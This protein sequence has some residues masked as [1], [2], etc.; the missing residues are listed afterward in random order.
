MC[1]QIYNYFNTNNLL[2]EQQYGFRS[3]HLT[4]LATIKL[5]DS[6][7]QNIDNTRLTKTPVILFLDLSK[8]FDTLNFD[9]LLHKLQYYGVNGVPLLLI[10]R[11]KCIIIPNMISLFLDFLR[12]ELLFLRD[13]F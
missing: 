3:G 2:C 5:I 7:I 6:I 1:G 8:A 4:K 11:M 10:K 13:L 12:I 9:I